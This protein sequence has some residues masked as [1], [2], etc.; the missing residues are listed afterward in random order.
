MK[1]HLRIEKRVV[2][3]DF[4]AKHLKV[5]ENNKDGFPQTLLERTDTTVKS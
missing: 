4:E 3:G 1:G 2:L 5:K